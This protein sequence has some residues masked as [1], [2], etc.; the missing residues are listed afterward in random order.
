MYVHGKVTDT[1]GNPISG[2]IIETWE[3][4]GD[5]LYDNQV[6]EVSFE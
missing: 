1:K 2:A 3:V 4:N 5:G 6:R